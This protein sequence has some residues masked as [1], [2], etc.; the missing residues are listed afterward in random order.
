MIRALFLLAAAPA[1]LAN[2]ISV[3]RGPRLVEPRPIETGVS[4]SVEKDDAFL[5]ADIYEIDHL[6]LDAPLSY[7]RGA[8]SITLP[9]GTLLSSFYTRRTKKRDRVD[10]V[11]CSKQLTTILGGKENLPAGLSKKI[12][13]TFRLC[14]FASA[15]KASIE[16]AFIAGGKGVFEGVEAIAPVAVT[17]S[18]DRRDTGST[19]FWEL[20]DVWGGSRRPKAK[21]VLVIDNDGKRF[22]GQRIKWERAGATGDTLWLTSVGTKETRLPHAIDAVFGVYDITIEAADTDS[23]TMTYRVDKLLEPKLF[24]DLNGSYQMRT[25]YIYY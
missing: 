11:Y 14:F 24:I 21:M 10:P 8:L 12:A 13:P 4:V 22:G 6:T 2:T 25:L 9:A 17:H 1:L 16:S 15:D 7:S 18:T 20:D 19:M 3:M 5:H 23:D